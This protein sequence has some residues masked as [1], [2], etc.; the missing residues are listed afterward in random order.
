MGPGDVAAIYFTQR[1][2]AGCPCVR[3]SRRSPFPQNYDSAGS[4][5]GW[6]WAQGYNLNCKKIKQFLISSSAIALLFGAHIYLYFRDLAGLHYFFFFFSFFLSLSPLH[7][8]SCRSNDLTLY[9]FCIVKSAQKTHPVFISRATS[10][11]VSS[12]ADEMYSGVEPFITV[13]E[14]KPPFSNQSAAGITF[15]S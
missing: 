14:S 3:T 9:A 15:G 1:A 12:I 7:A 5:R 6:L 11:M 8:P 4:P 10:A 2:N 13:S